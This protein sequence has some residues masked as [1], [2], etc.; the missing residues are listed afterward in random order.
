MVRNNLSETYKCI[1]CLEE[2]AISE[3]NKEHVLQK[4][5]GNFRGALT[6]IQQ[7]CRECNSSFAN[8]IDRILGRDSFETLYRLRYGMKFKTGN[9]PYERCVMTIAKE[10]QGDWA[11]VKVEVGLDPNHHQ[12]IVRQ[13]PQLGF[14]KKGTRD[15]IYF[16]LYELEKGLLLD[17]LDVDKASD[18][19]IISNNKEEWEK[20]SLYLNNK[21]IRAESGRNFDPIQ[22][23]KSDDGK[24]QI[25]VNFNI[26]DILVRGI[27]KTG[28]NYMAKMCGTGFASRNDFN[29]IRQFIRYDKLPPEELFK[30]VYPT[31]KPLLYN[32]YF[33][34]RRLGHILSL[35]WDITKRHVLAHVSLFNQITWT[36]IL[37][38]YFSGVFREIKNC[39]F[40]NIQNHE[41]TK[42]PSISRELLL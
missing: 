8:G 5:F 31:N 2:K 27:V 22:P 24:V 6:L 35:E 40:Y 25:Q 17:N 30:I 18:V 23:I 12:I 13:L 39:H 16:T 29:M 34:Y 41:V 11:G 10:G 4:S 9:I 7:V 20:L 14:I 36:I 32:D 21:V 33:K 42:L 28:F 19:K 26:D 3:F 38:K 1:Y 37:T 15:Y